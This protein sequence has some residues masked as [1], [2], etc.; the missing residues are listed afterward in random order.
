MDPLDG[1]HNG[2][3]PLKRPP[4]MGEMKRV[5]DAQALTL[6]PELHAVMRARGL[7]DE[8]VADRAK[9]DLA[10]LQAFLAGAAINP[11]WQRKLADWL[12]RAYDDPR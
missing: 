12:A 6:R 4:E 5:A 10:T 11:R 7:T 9:L 1:H 8:Q 2:H 3:Q